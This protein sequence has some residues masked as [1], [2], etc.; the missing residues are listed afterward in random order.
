MTHAEATTFADEAV[1]ALRDTVNAGWMHR[2]ELKD[3]EFDSLRDRD[4][5]KK[6]VAELE[7]KL[8]P[9]TDSGS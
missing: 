4:D 9:K 7:A 8:K 5:F 2:E 3:I 1:A 6:L